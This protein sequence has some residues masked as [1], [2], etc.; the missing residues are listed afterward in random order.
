M[1]L[2]LIDKSIREVENENDI[3]AN[4]MNS[5]RKLIRIENEKL[6]SIEMDLNENNRQLEQNLNQIDFIRK[7]KGFNCFELNFDLIL[8]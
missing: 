2:K 5:I 1:D 7:E 3:I 4:Q 8:N 6:I